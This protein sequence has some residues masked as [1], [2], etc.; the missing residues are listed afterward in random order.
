[1][2]P[3]EHRDSPNA[4][5]LLAQRRASIISLMLIGLYLFV[6]HLKI[7]LLMRFLLLNDEAKTL[8]YKNKYIPNPVM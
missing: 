4:V 8:I 3:S 1:M 7:K 6:C 2:S 5:L